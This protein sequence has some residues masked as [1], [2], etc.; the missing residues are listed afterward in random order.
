VTRLLSGAVLVVLAV[1][2]VWF[3]SDLVFFVVAEVLLLVAFGE[4]GALARASNLAIPEVPA[5]LAAVLTAAGFSRLTLSISWAS[6][7]VILM[8]AFVVVGVVTL[9]GWRRDANAVGLASAGLF[10]VFYLGLPFGAVVALREGDGR[11]ALLLLIVTIVISDSA[12]YY[13]GRAF[14]RHPL[15]PE[16]SPKKTIEG[17]VGGFIFGGLAFAIIGHWWLPAMPVPYRLAA[18]AGV[19][20]VGIAGDLFESMLKR[21]AGVKDSS[22]LIPGHGG[23]LD[24]L[25]ALLFAAPFYYVVLKYI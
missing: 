18:G 25:D 2:L 13:T 1:A 17:A 4:Y 15:A 20:A 5:A 23:L 9:F 3:A 6:L 12:Q 10:P 7:D 8:A 19:V 22:T 24:R 14:G 11:E 21:S 16:V